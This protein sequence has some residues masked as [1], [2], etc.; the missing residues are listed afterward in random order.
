M[1][2]SDDFP[3][4]QIQL[5]KLRY[6]SSVVELFFVKAFVVGASVGEASIVEV[7]VGETSLVGA[8]VVEASVVE[9][10]FLDKRNKTTTQF[11]KEHRF[12]LKKTSKT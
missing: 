4:S 8:L 9:A 6:Q 12:V 7:S 2:F 11:T 10:S 1:C 5:R 3:R